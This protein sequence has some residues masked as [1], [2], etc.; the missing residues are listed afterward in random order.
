[1]FNSLLLF[2]VFL[3]QSL[4]SCIQLGLFPLLSDIQ[5][6]FYCRGW[7]GLIAQGCHSS[8]LIIDPKTAQTIQVLEKHKSNVVKVRVQCNVF[9]ILFLPFYQPQIFIISNIQINYVFL[10]IYLSQDIQT[11]QFFPG[12]S[13]FKLRFLPLQV[14]LFQEQV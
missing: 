7:Q 5:C 1:M 10:W 2:V 13:Q 8:I 14:S 12:S 11:L 3:V 4:L 9:P 6:V